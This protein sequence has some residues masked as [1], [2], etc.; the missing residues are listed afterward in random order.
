MAT[1]GEQIQRVANGDAP[2]EVAD[3]LSQLS[4]MLSSEG[5]SLSGEARF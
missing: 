1:L 3:R 4:V 5:D 2:I